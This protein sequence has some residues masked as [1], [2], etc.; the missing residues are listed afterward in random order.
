[1]FRCFVNPHRPEEAVLYRNV[2]IP[3]LLFQSVFALVFGGV[4]FGLIIGSFVSTK[5]SKKKNALAGQFPSEPWKWRAD[6]AAGVIRTDRKAAIFSVCFATFWNLISFPIAFFILP[7]AMKSGQHAAFFVLLFPLVGTGLAIW[8]VREIAEVLRFGKAVFRMASVPGVIGGKLAGII[9]LPQKL[10]TAD[11]FHVR[12]KCTRTVTTGSGKNSNTEEQILWEETQDIATDAA[13]TPGETAIPVL[14][15]ISYNEPPTDPG[16]SSPIAW[17]LEATAK[18]PGIDLAIRFEVPVFKTPESSPHFKLDD[19]AI[20]PFLGKSDPLA[21]LRADRVHVRQTPQGTAF[22]FPTARFWG[23]ALFVTLFAIIWTGAVVGMVIA[24][25]HGDG[26]PLLFPIVFG[27][28]DIF[29]IYGFFVCWLGTGRVEID[30]STLRWKRGML[31]IGKNRALPAA[32]IRDF[33]AVRGSQSGNNIRYA[34][35]VTDKAGRQQK[36]SCEFSSKR[37]AEAMIAE[38]RR[39]L[40]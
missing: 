39:T 1:M 26:I 20:R 6:W 33:D 34:V 7:Q 14:F 31:G 12:L 27:F 40:P 18:N 25:K 22:I 10:Q 23:Q 21:D 24:R 36:I 5:S 17:R 29:I 32:D 28:F 38:L 37:A 16:A 2:R 13:K 30:R 19:S 4:G 35:A 11:G 8:A 9:Q 3:M 15:G